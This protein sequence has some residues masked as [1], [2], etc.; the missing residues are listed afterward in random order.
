MKCSQLLL[1]HR[2]YWPHKP[3]VGRN[4]CTYCVLHTNNYCCQISHLP[5]Y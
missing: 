1:A 5:N 2:K 3:K 4:L